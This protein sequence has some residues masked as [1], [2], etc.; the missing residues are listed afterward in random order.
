[1]RYRRPSAGSGGGPSRQLDF[2]NRDWDYS[3]VRV[4]G[5]AGGSEER[6]LVEQLP[7]LPVGRR[8]DRRCSRAVFQFDQ[9]G[10]KLLPGSSTTR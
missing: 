10:V 6:L 5:L 8:G 3:G 9:L 7:R 1:M 4:D 2:C